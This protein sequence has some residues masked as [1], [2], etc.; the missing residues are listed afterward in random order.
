LSIS[1]RQPILG[2]KVHASVRNVHGRKALISDEEMQVLTADF[3]KSVQCAPLV[4]KR[5]SLGPT[6]RDTNRLPRRVYE[7]KDGKRVSLST[8]FAGSTTLRHLEKCLMKFFALYLMSLFACT[9]SSGKSYA[10]GTNALSD[11]YGNPLSPEPAGV[12]G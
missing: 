2:P 7:E 4:F 12:Y 8:I 1:A 5:S 9:Y 6:T 11:Q 3:L 10:K